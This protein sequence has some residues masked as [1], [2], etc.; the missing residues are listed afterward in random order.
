MPK[1]WHIEKTIH[2]LKVDV[3]ASWNNLKDACL[4]E[5]LLISV[6]KE[7]G[8]PLVN[9]TSG[10]LGNDVPKTKEWLENHSKKMLGNNFAKGNKYSNE[11][12]KHLSNVRKGV[13]KPPIM[14]LDC[15]K[16]CGGGSNIRQ[17]Q[18]H[19]NHIGYFEL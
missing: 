14:C 11:I 19:Q 17:H 5:K 15:G 8:H 2:G 7:L 1:N 13:K 16:I 4:H 3:I 6:F 18:K 9:K 10:G 12:R